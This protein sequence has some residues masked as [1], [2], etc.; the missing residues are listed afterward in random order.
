MKSRWDCLEIVWESYMKCKLNHYVGI[1]LK[2]AIK[3]GIKHTFSQM[4][5]GRRPVCFFVYGGFVF[6]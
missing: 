3:T 4:S 1:V 5:A 2:Y 6:L